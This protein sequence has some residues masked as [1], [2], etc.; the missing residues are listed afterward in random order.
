MPTD[1]LIIGSALG[2]TPEQ[3]REAQE[4]ES[5]NKGGSPEGVAKVYK[6]MVATEE[7]MADPYFENIRQKA[8]KR[9]RRRMKIQTAKEKGERVA[10][11]E[12]YFQPAFDRWMAKNKHLFSTP[13]LFELKMTPTERLPFSRL[14]PHQESAL[15]AV[16]GEGVYHRITSGH[17]QYDT[18]KPADS[19]LIR[20]RGY[21]PI[22]FRGKEPGNRTFYML[23]IGDFIKERETCGEAS[24]TELRAREIGHKI[25]L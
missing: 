16:E 17:S 4:A 6:A 12:S 1:P 14:E 19:F 9:E 8:A 2:L 25:S 5:V 22:M 7:Q 23:R 15:L 20:G 10:T 11:E 24:I 18:K 3:V 21:I 13:C